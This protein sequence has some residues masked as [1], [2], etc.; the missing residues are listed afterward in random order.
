MNKEFLKE[1][2]K[3][4]SVSGHEIA[5]QKKVIAHMSPFCDE[6]LHDATGDVISVLNPKSKAKVLLCGHIDEIG[7]LVTR[8]M[9]N[10]MLKI[11][12][13]GGIHPVLYLGTHVQI[14]GKNGSIAGV[15]IT[16]SSLETNA[17]VT[18]GDLTIDIGVYSKD[19]A[20]VYVSIG[21][22]VCAATDIVEMLGTKFSGR[23]L[24]DR[25]GAF[26]I[27]EALKKAKEKKATCGI[28][29]A[30]TCGEE[31][32]MR[33]AYHVSKRVEPT[34]AIIIDVTYASDYPGV[35]ANASGEVSLGKGGVLCENSMIN[36]C[37]N[38]ALRQ[39]AEDKNIPMQWEVFAGKAG[40]DGDMVHFTNGGVPIALISIPLRYMHSSI[41][42]G[43]YT[44]I[45]SIIDWISEFLVR[46]DETF[47]FDPFLS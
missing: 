9:D 6:I 27:L 28:Y 26:I 43:D 46:F 30:T 40:T 22:P 29:A 16:D 36:N 19:E 11:T 38:E 23:A 39:I 3:T 33:G 21:D 25:I 31:T 10:G 20:Q 2:L 41:E 42:M 7:F 12:K 13:A 14:V 4:P 15:V 1:M 45:E 44:D 18:V 47:N 24:D 32:T 35:D 8:I 17:N 37:L 5:L 34:C